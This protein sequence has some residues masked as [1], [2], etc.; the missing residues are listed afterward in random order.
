L[1]LRESIRDLVEERFGFMPVGVGT[2]LELE[3]DPK[4][5][6]SWHRRAA[7]IGTPEAFLELV[8]LPRE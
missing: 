5:L 4:V 2:R 3:S 6:R 7:T 1:A 8:G